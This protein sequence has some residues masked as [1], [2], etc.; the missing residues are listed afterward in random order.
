ML[1]SLVIVSCHSR[2]TPR[3]LCPGSSSQFGSH[4]SRPSPLY[5][6]HYALSFQLLKDTPPQR[7]LVNSFA[8]NS[9]RTLFIVTGGVPPRGPAY[10]D[11]DPLF[12]ISHLLSP[13]FSSFCALF[14][15]FLHSRKTQL[16]SFQ[17]IPHSLRK[18]PGVGVGTAEGTADKI[19]PDGS[20]ALH[21]RHGRGGR[22]L[23]PP[24]RSVSAR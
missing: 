2:R 24:A 20:P 1:T 5:P 21:D 14:C 17:A 23:Q 12:P 4:P 3:S 9:L 6:I 11:S 15:T 18:T 10:H 8:I 16:L 19:R 22:V 13:F 7:P